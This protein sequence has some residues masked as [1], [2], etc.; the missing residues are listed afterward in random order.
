MATNFSTCRD[1]SLGKYS[2]NG[3]SSQDLIPCPAG[4]YCPV[5]TGVYTNF[6]CPEGTY[7]SV[8][9]LER[10]DQCLNCTLGNYCPLASTVPTACPVGKYNKYE[11]GT[12]ASICQMCEPGW[13]CPTSGMW[14]MTTRCDPGHYCHDGTSFADQFPCPLGSYTDAVNLTIAAE[15]TPCPARFACSQTIGTQSNTIEPCAPGHYCPLST[16]SPTSFDCPPGTYTNRTDLE[17]ASECTICP[18][19]FYRAGGA[20]AVSGDCAAGHYCP[21]GTPTATTNPCPTGTFSPATDNDDVGDCIEAPPGHYSV[22]GV[23]NPTQCNAGFYTNQNMTESYVNSNSATFPSCTACPAGYY[24]PTGTIDPFPCGVGYYSAVGAVSCS[25]CD[26]GHYCASTTNTRTAMLNDGG[27]WSDSHQLAGQ[28]FNGTY[29]PSGQDTVPTL[30]TNACPIAQYCPTATPTPLNCPAGRYNPHVGRDEVSDCTIV[31]AGKYSVEQSSAITGDC[32]PGYYCPEGSTSPAAVPCPARYYRTTS[33]ARSADDCSLCTAGSYCEIGSVTPTM[34]TRGFYCITGIDDPEPC[35]IGTFGNSTGLKQIEDCSPCSP[36]QFCDGFGLPAPRGPCDPGYYCLSGSYTSAPHAPGSPTVAEPSAIGGLCPAGGYCPTGSS[37]PASCDPGTYNNFT[38]AVAPVDCQNC[39]PG[40]YCAGTNNPAPSGLCDAGYYCT[41]SALSPTQHLTPEGFYTLPGSSAPVPCVPGTFNSQ[42]GQ[43]ACTP[44]VEGFYC[45]NQSTITLTVCPRGSY[46]DEGTAVPMKCPV[47]TFSNKLQNRNVTDCTPCTPGMYCYGNGLTAPTGPCSESYYCPGGQNLPSDA[48]YEC[49]AGHYCPEGGSFPQPC[50]AGFYT[51]A[52]GNNN[53]SQCLPCA[54]GSACESSGLAAPSSLTDPGHYCQSGC[55]AAN[56]VGTIGTDQNG[57][58]PVGH[59]C[60][61]GSILPQKCPEMTFVNY[62]G[63]AVCTTCPPGFYCDGVSTSIIIDCPQGSYCP[64]GTGVTQPKCPRGFFGHSTNL[65]AVEECSPCDPGKY[66]SQEGLTAV[67]GDCKAGYVCTAG[68]E[69]EYGMIGSSANTPCPVGE[70]CPTGSYQGI[71]CPPKTYNPST[72]STNSAACLYCSVGQFCSTY[73]LSTPTGP[74]SAGYVCLRGADTSKPTT[75][76]SVTDPATSTTIIIGGSITIPGTYSLNGSSTAT[77]CDAGYYNTLEGQD[78]CLETPTGYF[79]YVGS[80]DYTTNIGLPGYYY[81]A[82]TRYDTEYPCPEGT[83]SNTTGNQNVSDCIAAPPGYYAQGTGNIAPTGK[84]AEG[85]YCTLSAVTSMPT[86]STTGGPCVPSEYCPEGSAYPQDCPG[87][88]YCADSSGQITGDISAGYYGLKKISTPTPVAV[89]DGLDL[90]GD[91]CPLGH[92]CI[93]GSVSPT[94]CPSGTYSNQT[95]NIELNDCMPCLPG[96]QC[97]NEGTEFPTLP[98][99]TGFLCPS[100]T[101]SATQRCQ[102]GYRCPEGTAEMLPCSPG[103]YQDELEMA[104]CDPCPAS[105]Y[106]KVQAETPVTCPVGH[107]CPQSTPSPTTYPCPASTFSNRTGLSSSLECTLSLPGTASISTG[108]TAPSDE[109][110][111][112]HYCLRGAS[113]IYPSGGTTGDVCSAG[114]VCLS[115][116]S[117]PYP[118]DYITGY[119]TPPGTYSNAGSCTEIGCAPGTYTSTEASPSCLPCPAGSMCVVNTTTPESCPL[120]SYCPDSTFK[121]ILCPN[122]TFGASINLTS[123]SECLSCLAGQY[124]R[125]GRVS[126]TCSEGY[127]CR[128]GMDTPTPMISYTIE[129]MYDVHG[130][131]AAL[132]GGQCPPGHYCASGTVDPIMCQNSTIRADTHGVSKDDCGLCPGGYICYPGNPV[133]V[134]CYKGYYCEVNKPEVACPAGTYQPNWSMDSKD[135]CSN[136]PPGFLCLD[137]GTSNYTQY[138]C[139]PGHHC[140]E[141]ALSAVDCPSGTYR[142]INRGRDVDDC[143]ICPRGY[144]CGNATVVPTACRPGEVCPEGSSFAQLCP[145]RFYCPGITSEAIPCPP[146]YFCPQNSSAPIR[147]PQG[148][149]CPTN[150]YEANPCPLGSIGLFD[151]NSSRVNLEDSCMLCSAGKYG[152]DPDR[153]VCSPCTPG[154]VCHEGC[155]SKYPTDIASDG[156]YQCPKGHYCEKGSK[157]PTPCPAGSHNPHSLAGNHTECKLCGTDL[158]QHLEGQAEC[159]ACSTSSIST[160]GATTCKCLGLNRAFQ[161]SDGFCICQP[162]YE[163]YDE[164]FQ[165]QSDEDGN[166]DCQP[167]VFDRCLD[168]QVRDLFGICR[169]FDDCSLQCGE[170]GGKYVQRLGICEC[171]ELDDLATVCDS[172]C[173]DASL[174]TIFDTKLNM[175]VVRNTTHIISTAKTSELP[176]FAGELD[177]SHS[178][179]ALDAYG[180]DCKSPYE[181]KCASSYSGCNVYSMEATG[182]GFVGLFGS[183]L[184]ENAGSGTKRRTTASRR[185]RRSLAKTSIV[186]GSVDVEDRD[187]YE[188]KQRRLEE[189]SLSVNSIN[190]P[191]VCIQ[192]GDSML[193][194]VSNDK[195][196]QYEK[197]SLLNTNPRFDYGAFRDLDDI[198]KSSSTVDMFGFTFSKPGV[199]VFSMSDAP[200]KLSIVAVMEDSV[201]CNTK[202]PFTPLTES[203]LV[204]INAK[205]KGDLILEPDWLVIG[206]LIVGLL[207]MVFGVVGTLYYFR[208][209]AWKTHVASTAKY[210]ERSQK[211]NVDKF[212]DKGNI[213]KHDAKIL[214]T[215]EPGSEL[216]GKSGTGGG[217]DDDD[218]SDNGGMANYGG[219]GFEA[220]EIIDRLQRHHDIMEKEFLNQHELSNNLHKA[221]LQEADE[222]KQMVSMGG[223]GSGFAGA[224]SADAASKAL[225]KMLKSESASRRLHEGSVEANEATAF[226]KIK[227]LVDLLEIGP[228][229]VAGDIISDIKNQDPPDGSESLAAICTDLDDMKVF[230]DDDIISLLEGEKRRLGIVKKSWDAAVRTHPAALDEKVTTL[231]S[232]CRRSDIS[233]DYESD[234]LADSLSEFSQQVPS[235][236]NTLND[237]EG[238]L[239]RNLKAE[240]HMSEKIIQR[241]MTSFSSL[242]NQL[243]DKILN[244]Y[245]GFEEA[246]GLVD[247]KRLEAKEVRK[248]LED[249]IDIAL[250]EI[251]GGTYGGGTLSRPD[252][253][254]ATMQDIKGLSE[255]TSLEEMNQKMALEQMAATQLEEERAHEREL[256]LQKTL[257]NNSDI[258]DE[259]KQDLLNNLDDDRR[260]MEEAMELE[261]LRQEE[262]LKQLVNASDGVAELDEKSE[263]AK[264]TAASKLITQQRQEMEALEGRD[265]IDED[266][267][268]YEIKMLQ[269]EEINAIRARSALEGRRKLATLLVGQEKKRMQIFLDRCNSST[270]VQNELDRLDNEDS[271][272]RVKVLALVEQDLNLA[273]ESCKA[274]QDVELERGATVEDVKGYLLQQ[275]EIALDDLTAELDALPSDQHGV[276]REG[277][278]ALERVRSKAL[279]SRINPSERLRMLNVL[280]EIEEGYAK[281]FILAK[282]RMDTNLFGQHTAAAR[283]KI[284]DDDE[285][286]AFDKKSNVKSAEMIEA[287]IERNGQT[288]SFLKEARADMQSSDAS[289]LVALYSFAKNLLEQFDSLYDK[290]KQYEKDFVK[291]VAER[292]EAELSFDDD[293]SSKIFEAE[294]EER[295]RERFGKSLP[296]AVASILGHHFAAGDDDEAK[297]AALKQLHE[298][299]MKEVKFAL[300]RD[301]KR[302]KDGLKAK[303]AARRAQ[304]MAQLQEKGAS[305]QETEEEEQ[306][307]DEAEGE[308]MAALVASLD[309]KEAKA[310]EEEAERQMKQ[311]GD[312]VDPKHELARLLASH[313]EGL[314]ALQSDL[315]AE[316]KRKHDLLK[317]K[318]EARRRAKKKGLVDSG[319]ESAEVKAEMSNFDSDANLEEQQLLAAIDV[320]NKK[321]VSATLQQYARSEK[322]VEDFDP[323]LQRLRKLHVDNLHNLTATMGDKQKLARKSLEGKLKLRRAKKLQEMAKFNT[324]SEEVQKTEEELAKQEFEDLQSFDASSAEELTELIAEEKQMQAVATKQGGGENYQPELERLKKLNE[325]RLKDLKRESEMSMKDRKAALKKRLEAKRKKKELMMKQKGA[326]DDEVEKEI[327]R[328]EADAVEKEKAFAAK[329]EAE[330]KAL[331]ESAENSA[332]AVR[333]LSEGIVVDDSAEVLERLKNLHNTELNHLQQS[334]NAKAAAKRKELMARLAAK[335]AEKMAKLAERGASEAQI[336]A[337]EKLA[338]TQSKAA[339]RKLESEIDKD[340]AAAV[341]ETKQMQNVAISGVGGGVDYELELARVK[342]VHEVGLRD[343][344]AQLEKGKRERRAQLKQRLEAQRRAK[345]ARMKKQGLC[346]E[347]IEAEMANM[348]KASEVEMEKLDVALEGEREELDDMKSEG[349][350]MTARG[351]A[352]TDEELAALKALHEQEMEQLKLKMEAENERQKEQLLAEL[353]ALKEKKILDVIERGGGEGEIEAAVKSLENEAEVALNQLKVTQQACNAEKTKVKEDEHLD[354]VDAASVGDFDYNAHLAKMKAD[355]SKDMLALQHS[356]ESDKAKRKSALRDKLAARRKAREAKAKAKGG[357]SDEVVKAELAAEDAKAALEL[358]KLENT[359][360][361]DQ[362]KE[363]EK[364]ESHGNMVSGNIANQEE[365]MLKLQAYHEMEVK[366]LREEMAAEK[367]A[368]LAQLEAERTVE[369]AVVKQEMQE[370]GASEEDIEGEMEEIDG[371]LDKSIAVEKELIDEKLEGKLEMKSKDFESAQEKQLGDNERLHKLKSQNEQDIAAMK[372]EIGAK[373]KEKKGALKARLEKRRK[374]KMKMIH[375]KV[376]A[377]KEE[378]T[379]AMDDLLAKEKEEIAKVDEEFNTEMKQQE[380]AISS[381]LVNEMRNDHDATVAAEKAMRDEIAKLKAFNTENDKKL[382]EQMQVAM[383]E[384]ARQMQEAM[385][386]KMEEMANMLAEMGGAEREKKEKEIELSVKKDGKNMLSEM[387]SKVKQQA[388]KENLEA[389]KGQM[390]EARAVVDT[391]ARLAEEEAR[392]RR[393]EEEERAKLDRMKK[394]EAEKNEGRKGELDAKKNKQKQKLAERLKKKRQKELKKKQE[395]QLE[396]LKK[397]QEKEEE[398]QERVVSGAGGEKKSLKK[399]KALAPWEVSLEK[400]RAEIAGEDNEMKEEEVE[401]A[402][403]SMIGDGDVVTD[404]FVQKAVER[405]FSDRHNRET[406]ALLTAQYKER[407]GKLREA[408]NAVFDGKSIKRKQLL[409]DENLGEGERTAKMRDLDEEFSGKREEAERGV[410]SQM[411]EAHMMQQIALRQQQLEEMRQAN[412]ATT[413]KSEEELAA[414]A[415]RAQEVMKA[416]QERIEKEKLEKIAALEEEKRVALEKLEQDKLKAMRELEESIKG[417]QEMATKKLEEEKKEMVKK[418]KE[419]MEKRMNELDNTANDEEKN[420]LIKKF[421]EEHSAQMDALEQTKLD[422]KNKL[423]DKLKARREKKRLALE[424][425]KK[426]MEGKKEKEIELVE[427][428]ANSALS[429]AG[430]VASGD[431]GK[432]GMRTAKKRFLLAGKKVLAAAKFSKVRSFKVLGGKVGESGVGLT[433]SGGIGGGGTPAWVGEKLESIERALASLAG[434][435]GGAGASGGGGG[436]VSYQDPRDV[437]LLPPASNELKSREE[438]DLSTFEVVRMGWARR[439]AQIVGMGDSVAIKIADALPRSTYERNA[440]RNSYYYDDGAKTL[441][442]H[443]ERFGSQGDVMMCLV[444]ALSHIKVNPSDLSDDGSVGFVSEYHRELKM[445]TNELA[446]GRG[447]S[448][449]GGGRGVGSGGQLKVDISMRD[450]QSA[451]GFGGKAG[452][453][454]GADFFSEEAMVKRMKAYAQATG[455]SKVGEVV[456]RWEGGRAR[457]ETEDV[458]A[459]SDEED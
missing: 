239:V 401:Q 243:R 314:S 102:R 333:T 363:V 109:C 197:D 391:A 164:N 255:N 27:T 364:V 386:K 393:E 371:R 268:Q 209:Q 1:A 427:K 450:L 32:D 113:T 120:Y 48:D 343:L 63:A 22:G 96:L 77:A 396:N 413:S 323:E 303:L 117:T 64:S 407:S 163:F 122:G 34:C 341:E 236:V 81:P 299:E 354:M 321:T 172:E 107:Y 82:G 229:L 338:V 204:A 347:E 399:A 312:G 100:G 227:R 345:A 455:G 327:E 379:E 235:F 86:N 58:C 14:Q 155:R 315:N 2:S 287:Q 356:M 324:S 409:L 154:Y 25:A 168:K 325:E 342:G 335:K 351:G 385:A 366:M 292:G 222:L 129:E 406:S 372:A 179:E 263:E 144:S 417:E 251:D 153:L 174:F 446:V 91:V 318:L 447:A 380:A 433:A 225:L 246:R 15:C 457:G 344:S 41:G 339:I 394:E 195:Y 414:E 138:P 282:D 286:A 247:A 68:S 110:G 238:V 395:H 171:Y 285:Q 18:P 288:L 28:C 35:R 421:N 370:L 71:Q 30:I 123:P 118:S 84:C 334:L 332:E 97:P 291:I 167:V 147:C 24:C 210:R 59:Y 214:P 160:P 304:K 439:I 369:K 142:G 308:A 352:G 50:P 85:F 162:G 226:S 112:G 44:C 80:S 185:A 169:D 57:V 403:V 441:Y 9:S 284:D 13:A 377:S 43:A 11:R 105:F 360:S 319:K 108:L 290:T 297:M 392:R 196:P 442:V 317:A 98:C 388:V 72:T 78:A 253:S 283:N 265:F 29:C 278:V 456:S 432:D 52:T 424:K 378:K 281:S 46:C 79:T 269:F 47:G 170:N 230:L 329:V 150:S 250:A 316:K 276:N 88:S 452:A 51:P 245:N 188:R 305:V 176:N 390:E 128:S 4:Y 261:R 231:L 134:P 408:L 6:P 213:F 152:D 410:S 264:Q 279:L 252:L 337:A 31:P 440:F 23:T 124:C 248:D 444:H 336:E 60:P 133:P 66:C 203:N 101:S 121:P 137:V 411:E 359:L 173:R 240:P 459:L 93:Q 298:K 368:L 437:L 53:I 244:I 45:L 177:C 389:E 443:V 449:G 224:D 191:V 190:D 202:A 423:E 8:T 350:T 241:S 33:G 136:C 212:H 412:L 257:E 187:V 103:T 55:I 70:Y 242:L 206:C 140:P 181:P 39:D 381:K 220:R 62:T 237:T 430:V 330:T 373:Q 199:Y 159:F 94:A 436:N 56:P 274:R 49:P 382:Q 273:L 5:R 186:N 429:V 320:E 300:E 431:S 111:P 453:A 420:M 259:E 149:F 256:E 302:A 374:A 438:E 183:A 211:T 161:T 458:L 21:A 115:G 260:E 361:A 193:Y 309:K 289:V 232:T 20:A 165:R 194:R 348:V 114:Y 151:T 37:F 184:I 448:A 233:T 405:V 40:M 375:G 435:V 422:K 400:A 104:D 404:M 365:L 216:V 295:F 92:Y 10:A 418:H 148:T 74:C 217:D 180:L 146:G 54:A 207:V 16:P 419:D 182:D 454:D 271:G 215:E 3:A 234:K 61:S 175:L 294:S 143:S 19:S 12:S 126:G 397:S 192:R 357:D 249:V 384:N 416:Q 353:E 83:Y 428:V 426:E 415:K 178:G 326:T 65:G 322:A 87:G 254:D 69:N 313:G 205:R 355:N 293:K 141:K 296:D 131:W 221:L 38:G 328:M 266:D 7:S 383:E 367:A 387:V 402:L 36:G 135:S 280:G 201:A 90:N 208:T 200:E 127:F 349:L 106:C 262:E 198:A 362:A 95:G 272:T 425:K 331:I 139:P 116:A 376:G 157:I 434:K 166:V 258:T 67:E 223:G 89:Y 358:Q 145:P 158:Y 75:S 445:V 17:Y 218:D 130:F 270:Y 340:E 132:N 42:T 119:P 73:G 76:A 398:M 307:L 306:K 228:E 267:P 346:D 311:I 275:M 156:G 310:L 99:T 219:S 451:S 125:D 26:A 277:E 301:G 189:D